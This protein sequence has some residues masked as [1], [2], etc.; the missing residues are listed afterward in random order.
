[1]TQQQV[2]SDTVLGC[3]C[4]FT[5]CRRLFVAP[6]PG[7]W[8]IIDSK[9]SPAEVRKCLA[10]LCS[11]DR[12]TLLKLMLVNFH[13][14]CHYHQCLTTVAGIQF[15]ETATQIFILRCQLFGE[16]KDLRL[17]LL[18][19]NKELSQSDLASDLKFREAEFHIYCEGIPPLSD[20]KKFLYTEEGRIVEGTFRGIP[21]MVT[22]AKDGDLYVTYVGIGKR[23][24]IPIGSRILME[25]A[26]SNIESLAAASMFN[27]YNNRNVPEWYPF[28]RGYPYKLLTSLL[29]DVFV[30]YQEYTPS[31]QWRIHNLICYLAL[32]AGGRPIRPDDP[33]NSCGE[34]LLRIVQV[35]MELSE[36]MSL[37]DIGL[38][39]LEDRLQVLGYARLD[40]NQAQLRQSNK[41]RTAEWKNALTLYRW[42]ASD[43]YQQQETLFT[44]A[45]LRATFQ[46]EYLEDWVK[47]PKPPLTFSMTD[48]DLPRL[49]VVANELERGVA[50]MKYL[51]TADVLKQA[52]SSSV[53]T[54]P[55]KRSHV[56]CPRKDEECGTIVDLEKIRDTRGCT[57]E[58]MVRSL[59]E[60]RLIVDDAE[61]LAELLTE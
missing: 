53:I 25:C 61:F 38:Q 54:C 23:K 15:F 24:R 39:Q 3:L 43:F 20:L 18:E 33:K 11:Y 56:Y 42:I 55:L 28:S 48:Q 51:F 35:L 52:M 44:R 22:L 32:N 8:K 10:S 60:D 31:E 27:Y 34:K 41:T 29:N 7:S 9:L 5:F 50:W 40:E 17:P 59:L 57:F 13:E 26:A 45:G 6:P 16:C 58:V 30:K 14:V 12:E 47:Y 1:M 37:K 21:L 46:E 2:F 49:V 19:N 4:P 36:D